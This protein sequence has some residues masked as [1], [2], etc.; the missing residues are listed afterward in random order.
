M[1]HDPNAARITIADEQVDPKQLETL[2]Q[3]AALGRMSANLIHDIS[4]PLTAVALCLQEGNNPTDSSIQRAQRNIE[5]LQRYVSTARQQIQIPHSS[6]PFD[7]ND[8]FE[9][10][11]DALYPIA[12]QQSIILHFIGCRGLILEGDPV[13]FQQIITNLAV[14]AIEASANAHPTHASAPNVVIQV[15]VSRIDL[16]IT[17]QDKGTGIRPEVLPHIFEPFYSTK[18]KTEVSGLG[19]GLYAAKHSVE[20]TFKG[21]IGVESVIGQ[22]TTFTVK[23][24]RTRQ[25][26]KHNQ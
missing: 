12:A 11:K 25:F 13:K 4:N 3:L 9:R 14:N 20:T 2:Q 1:A 15:S 16:V 5:T 26:I 7:I 6:Q 21:T 22:G 17:I 23:F 10:L 8:E 24:P 18:Q 19:I